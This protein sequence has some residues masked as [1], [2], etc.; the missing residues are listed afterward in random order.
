M[1]S[2]LTETYQVIDIMIQKNQLK[3]RDYIT[4]WKEDLAM[5]AY[6]LCLEFPKLTV[7]EAVEKAYRQ[8]TNKLRLIN[9]AGYATTLPFA[10]VSN[11]DLNAGT[12]IPEN[13][14]NVERDAKWKEQ[15]ESIKPLLEDM[16]I[17]IV[18]RLL[19]NKKILEIAAEL[20][21]HS[22]TIRR[23]V[24]RIQDKVE[25]V[26]HHEKDNMD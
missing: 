11:A 4:G 18:E 14:S 9:D 26:K 22:S 6:T 8:D 21:I 25:R 23:T 20:G 17:Q 19:D 10:S 2:K 7:A 3:L 16:E 13:T 24:V 15:F 1:D 12:P 5:E